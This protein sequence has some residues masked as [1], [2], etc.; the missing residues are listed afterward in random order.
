MLYSGSQCCTRNLS[1]VLGTSVVYSGPQCCTQDLSVVL[2]TSVGYSG[3]TAGLTVAP[4]QTVLDGL[5]LKVPAGHMLA[6]VGYSGGGKST[7]AALLE[8]SGDSLA[9][10]LML[11]HSFLNFY[12]FDF[13]ERA[14]SLVNVVGRN[15]LLL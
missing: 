11:W 8:R 15:G 1:V 3:G 5:R 12:R 13:V 2:G 6:L 14:G 10:S 7:C 4:P 9:S